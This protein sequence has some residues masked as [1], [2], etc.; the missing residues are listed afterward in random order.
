MGKHEKLEN[1]L[2]NFPA[3]T[4]TY[5]VYK[6]LAIIFNVSLN[7][8]ELDCKFFKILKNTITKLVK[9]KPEERLKLDD[10]KNNL[11]QL[12]QFT[13]TSQM[14]KFL[15]LNVF[16]RFEGDSNIYKYNTKNSF[17]F[18]SGARMSQMITNIHVR[19]SKDDYQL[20]QRDTNLCG[21]FATMLLLSYSLLDFFKQIQFFEE[22]KKY[23]ELERIVKDPE[24]LN[25]LI[26]VCCGVISPRSF[27]G[28]NHGRLDYDFQIQA[29]LQ[30]LS[31]K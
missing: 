8:N 26:N 19:F 2:N 6:E 18:M 23:D 16:L 17:G 12:E 22:E 13:I 9:V 4:S 20:T 15:L 14:R 25:Q 7:P 3:E 29:Q 31:K 28:L 11:E 27:N 30:D 21:S 10:V 24:F 1:F 5:S